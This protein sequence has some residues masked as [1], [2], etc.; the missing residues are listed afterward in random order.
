MAIDA[1]V[2]GSGPN[3]L[4]AAI[5][6]ARAGHSVVIYEAADQIGGGMRSGELTLPGFTHDICSTI[7]ALG[8]ASPVLRSFPLEKYGLQWVRPSAPLAHPFDS[9]SAAVLEHSI[10][11]TGKT[12]GED[13][14]NYRKFVGPFVRNSE[15]L[16][17]DIL[18]PLSLPKHPFL[19]AR[20]GFYGVQSASYA[21][22]RLFRNEEARALFA[23]LAAHAIMP[24]EKPLTAA[25]GLILGMLGHVTGWPVARGGSQQL[26]NALA[27]YFKS[28]GGEIITGNPVTSLEELP[29]ARAILCDITPRQ[30]IRIA[31]DRL[32][33]RY[34]QSLEQY[35]Y[36]P[37]VFK[38]DW[39][40]RGPIPWKA[41]GCKRAG[42]VHVGG[43][44]AEIAA[45]E[46]A[47]WEGR[48]PSRPFVLV[49]QPTLFDPS[50]APAGRHIAWAYCHVPNGSTSDRTEQIESQIERFAPGFRDQV[51]ARSTMTT[52]QFE[53]H[54][55]NYIGGD[56]NGGVQ[57]LRQLFFRPTMKRVPYA[58]PVKGLY[59]CS[60]STPPGGGVHGMGGYHAAQA[61]LR[62]IFKI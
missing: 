29:P 34:K 28:L 41:E 42:T 46:R 10:E 14:N 58:T 37:G 48:H 52:R 26:A 39:A 11:E 1:I 40:L 24:L 19:M 60:A 18:G 5:V 22:S 50:R 20:F 44:L 49:T 55:A 32:P 2:I 9:G 17:Q 54:N 47:V 16:F 7:H 38:M 3:G 51:L 6:L 15:A 59:L 53:Q 62:D 43:T 8:A 4:A 57:D 61:A 12:L 23:G 30:L 36:G 21:A 13:S 27:A 31:S 33:S 35:R 56:I 25:F 45:A